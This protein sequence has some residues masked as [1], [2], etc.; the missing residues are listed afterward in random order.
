MGRDKRTISTPY[1]PLKIITDFK[2][3]IEG[4]PGYIFGATAATTVEIQVDNVK[5]KEQF[6]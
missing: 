3:V 4:L 6:Q 1:Q 2:Y 5:I